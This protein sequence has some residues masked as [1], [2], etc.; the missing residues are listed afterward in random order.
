MVAARV[1]ITDRDISQDNAD[2]T[3]YHSPN[4]PKDS[5]FLYENTS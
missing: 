2:K 5:D 3:R 1:I 4:S